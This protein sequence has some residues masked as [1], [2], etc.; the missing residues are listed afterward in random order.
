MLGSFFY[1]I[2]N[3]NLLFK[4]YWKLTSN[5]SVTRAITCT[6]SSNFEVT[7]FTI[8]FLNTSVHN[9]I[10]RTLQL[11]E[12]GTTNLFVIGQTNKHLYSKNYFWTLENWPKF[13]DQIFNYSNMYYLVV[14][15]SL[16]SS[17]FT[18]I[19]INYTSKWSKFI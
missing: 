19:Y 17:E 15:R 5:L 4:L 10:T 14:N 6:F 9:L 1:I 13:S 18:V 3:E 8:L 2:F 16:S 11:Y 12:V 7:F